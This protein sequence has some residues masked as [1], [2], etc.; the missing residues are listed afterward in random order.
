MHHTGPEEE[1]REQQRLAEQQE[2]SHCRGQ[3]PGAL[4][5]PLRSD[6][7]VVGR[8]GA[9]RERTRRRSEPIRHVRRH[10]SC[11]ND[12]RCGEHQ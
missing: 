11:K 12:H 2:E 1:D 7:R 6:Q 8:C 10:H 4:N 3:G 9:S 5:A